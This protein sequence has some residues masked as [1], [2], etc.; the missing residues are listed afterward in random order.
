MV[1][2]ATRQAGADSISE[3]M[4]AAGYQGHGSLLNVGDAD[5]IA[6]VINDMQ[7]GVGAPTILI[8]NAGIT[9]DNLILRMQEDEWQQV[10]DINLTALF[11]YPRPVYG[12]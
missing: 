2:T 8:N 5:N 6:S 12:A 7:T 4:Q 1:G 10:M 9:Q 11:V 3:Y